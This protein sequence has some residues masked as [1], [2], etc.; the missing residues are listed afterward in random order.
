VV[1]ALSLADEDAPP[2]SRE[3]A[4]AV[5][6][7]PGTDATP[8]HASGTWATAD[9]SLSGDGNEFDP[10]TGWTYEGNETDPLLAAV[11]PAEVGPAPPIATAD[12]LFGPA[13]TGELPRVQGTAPQPKPQARPTA[14]PTPAARP[15]RSPARSRGL[16][17]PTHSGPKSPLADAAAAMKTALVTNSIEMEID[18]EDDDIITNGHEVVVTPLSPPESVAPSDQGDDV[19]SLLVRGR[20]LLSH[21]QDGKAVILLRRA[22]RLQPGNTHVQTWRQLGERRLLQAH[23][24]DAKPTQI[25]R[26]TAHRLDFWEGANELERQLLVAIDGKRTLARLMTAAPDDKLEFL[27]GMLATFNAKGWLSPLK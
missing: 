16:E 25:P 4:S 24:P 23:L 5:W 27:L 14:P 1:S 19:D 10:A 22:Q 18:D 3:E 26:L 17:I 7:L 9:E 2:V 20:E 15:A 13:A 21:G 11:A 8:R 6:S 12:E